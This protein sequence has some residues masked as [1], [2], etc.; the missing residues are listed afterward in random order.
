MTTERTHQEKEMEKL[1]S[2]L[3]KLLDNPAH[4]KHLQLIQEEKIRSIKSELEKISKIKE[5]LQQWDR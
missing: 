5:S 4:E 2:Q 1:Q 3:D